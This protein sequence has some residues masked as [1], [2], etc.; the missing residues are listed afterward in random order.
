LRKAKE[1]K[2][3]KRRGEKSI[4]NPDLKAQEQGHFSQYIE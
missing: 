1:K 2:K 3:W 4:I